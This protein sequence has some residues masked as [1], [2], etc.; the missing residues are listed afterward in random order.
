MAKPL[1]LEGYLTT[2][3]LLKRLPMSKPTFYRWI[4]RGWFGDL[5]KHD[6]RGNYYYV[7]PQDLSK[8][9]KLVQR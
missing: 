1:R 3:D 2:K 5:I 8:V 6:Q 9:I 7:E 4:K